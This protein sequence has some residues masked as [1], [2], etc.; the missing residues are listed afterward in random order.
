VILTRVRL[1][2]VFVAA[3][4]LAAVSV[5]ACGPA[6]TTPTIGAPYSQTDLRVGTGTEAVAGKAISVNYTGWLYDSAKTD[7]KGL[8]FDSSVGGTPLTFTLG[9][10]AVIEGFDRGLAGMKVGGARRLVV[11]SSLGYGGVRNG[12]IPAFSTMV[13]DVDL[14]DVQ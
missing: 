6:P 8:Q 4:A 9:A 12:A 5:A 2:V 14:V 1:G 10:G 3:A 11:P 13:F 7:Q